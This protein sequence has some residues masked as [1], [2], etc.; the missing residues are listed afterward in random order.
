MWANEVVA[1]FLEWLR[2]WNADRP[3]HARV[4]FYGLD[5]YSLWDSLRPILSWL[6][7]NAPDSV[8]AASHSCEGDVVDLLC[9][10]GSRPAA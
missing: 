10:S 3:A 2:A 1:D 6:Q 8:P 9:S 4:G 5:V 7:D